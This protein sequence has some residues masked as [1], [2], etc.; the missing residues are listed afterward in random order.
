MAQQQQ[1]TTPTF[2]CAHC[3]RSFTWKAE[4]AGKKGKCSC[5][6]LLT[7]PTAPP[8][9]PPPVEEEIDFDK[10]YDIAV[11]PPDAKPAAIPPPAKPAFIPPPRSVA[12][13]M[14]LE[15]AQRG[16]TS[17]EDAMSSKPRDVYAPAALLI[18]GMLAVSLWAFTHNK[19]PKS[20][21][22][23]TTTFALASIAIVV[24]KT[25]VLTGLMV[26]IAPHLGLSLG[27]LRTTA[28]KL[29]AIFVTAD[30]VL[31]WTDVYMRYNSGVPDSTGS[32]SFWII[33]I[34][35]VICAAVIA[36]L[37]H[38][39][40]GLEREEMAVVGF[41]LAAMSQG[42][43]FA[44]TLALAAILPPKS[45]ETPAAPHAPAATQAAK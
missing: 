32:L 5:G 45:Q 22:P 10:L 9:P 19:L 18:V 41:P 39:L 4:L 36:I 14:A 6:Q 42:A 29:A 26:Y 28:L 43:A 2:H 11:P 3:N 21:A 33:F 12:Q 44:L 30:A 35:V 27:L 15:R 17:F 1:T 7:I 31:V 25:L 16:K 23:P 24:I 40:F 13:S 8:S 34:R 20:S 37:L 38:Y